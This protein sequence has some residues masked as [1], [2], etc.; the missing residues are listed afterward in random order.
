MSLALL[1]CVTRIAARC[2]VGSIWKA[3]HLTI[4]NEGGHLTALHIDTTSCLFSIHYTKAL[5]AVERL[6]C[7]GG[8]PRF[9]L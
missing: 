9:R 5:S 4:E 2:I 8:R 3:K 1:I 7:L 6:R